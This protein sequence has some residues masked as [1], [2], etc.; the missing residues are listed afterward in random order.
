MHLTGV[1]RNLSRRS[2]AAALA[3]PILLATEEEKRPNILW[4]T[5]EDTGPH[6]GAYG[7]KYSVSPNLDKLATRGVIYRNAWSNA[8][9]CAP[10]RTTIISGLYPTSTGSEHMRSI[11]ALPENIKMFPCYLREAGYYTSNNAKE[12]YNLKHTG[13]VWDD[14]SKKAHWRNRKPKQPFFSVFNLEITHE[15]QIR[16]RPHELVHDPAKAPLPAYHPDTPEVRHDWAQYYDNI[17]VMDRQ[18]GQI[19][20]QLEEDG[21]ADNTIV[22]F[23]GD[24][25]S[26]MPRSKRWPYNSGLQVPLIISIPERYQHLAPKEYRAGGKSDRLVGF[27]D[28]APTI[29][30]LVGLRPPSH[31][32]GHAF[33]GKHIGPEQ[34]YLHGFRGRMDERYDLVRSVRDHRY[35]YIRNYMPH[36]IYGQHLAYM[37]ETPTTRVW[38]KLYDESKLH[39]P[40]TYF[41]EEKPVEEIYDLQSD[42]DEVHNLAKSPAH[43]QRLLQMRKVQQQFALK[44]RD[45]GL[46]PED[47]IHSRSEH[48]TP[49]EMGHDP[50]RYPIEK[51]LETA[52]LA[53][54]RTATAVPTLIQ[55]LE[56]SD[57][58]VRYWAATGLVIQGS[59]AVNQAR[60]VLRTKLSDPAPS[61]RIAA[62]EAL[63][64]YSTDEDAKEALKAL[65]ELAHVDRYGLYV[66]LAA[67]NA[68]DAAGAK[69]IMLRD[70]ISSLPKQS[71]TIPKRLQNYVPRLIEDITAR[72]NQ[73]FS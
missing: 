32:Q 17:T 51:I 1:K 67:L 64:R 50:K 28:L 24:H 4:I 45:V 29:L 65:V 39:P 21:L 16:T 71:E 38:K 15:S 47:E 10:A 7:D 54:S 36:K 69:A 44:T 72:L 11:T 49:Y 52:S 8:P 66:S 68:L 34:A 41:W 20:K 37:F 33:M 63:S 5:C 13:Q 23:F 58:A 3:A 12:D 31:L 55:N 6:L 62:A 70:Q 57:S 46:L 2:F 19:L 25:G 26:G 27:V 14:S 61:V 42:H 40:Q 9:V 60:A 18:A 48:S 35:V 59:E 73:P 43:R 53:S 56:H 30:N 22:F